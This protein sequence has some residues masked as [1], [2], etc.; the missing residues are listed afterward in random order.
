MERRAKL[1]ADHLTMG[2]E[3]EIAFEDVQGF[4]PSLGTKEGNQA[5]NKAKLIEI[6]CSYCGSKT[7][8]FNASVQ[9]C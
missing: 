2:H 5:I 3:L 7:S 4:L 8:R 9:L 6:S 1:L